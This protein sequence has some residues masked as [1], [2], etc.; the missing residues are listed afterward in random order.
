[1]DL[2][3]FTAEDL[4]FDEAAN[5]EVEQLL[6]TA[7]EAYGTPAAEQA[8]LR[9]FSK[10]PEGLTVL[11]AL[12]RYYY[13]QLRYEDALSVAD[14]AMNV[15]ANRL[16]IEPDWRTIDENDLANAVQQSMTQFRFYL[17][18]L[19][20]S[21][22]LNLRMGDP[23]GALERLQ[24]IARLDE[25]DRIGVKALIDLAN[26]ALAEQAGTTAVG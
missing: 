13:Y 10:A 5:P 18:A 15:V 2:L 11:V 21:A 8:L 17:Y 1:M 24:A 26:D 9:A 6:N 19:K 25:A 16:G 23:Q 22:Y 3:D 4:Y 12:Y 7:A 14:R 20:G